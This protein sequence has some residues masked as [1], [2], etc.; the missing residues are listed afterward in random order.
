MEIKKLS[1]CTLDEILMAWNRGFEGY[2]VTIN[3][4][5]QLFLNRMVA[6]G[7]SFD[8]SIVAFVQGEP[9]G[10]VVNGIRTIKDKIVAWN[11]GT[12]V[13]PAYRGKGVSKKLMDET[14]VIYEEA[15]VDIAVLEAIKENE[16]A[17]QLYKRYGYD[18]TDE[19]VFLTGQWAFDASL[20]VSIYYEHLHPEQLA[21]LPFYEHY[22]PWQCQWQSVKQGE[23]YVFYNVEGEAIGYSLLKK[24]WNTEGK[25]DQ[26]VL[27]QLELIDQTQ[28]DYL[29]HMLTAIVESD[30]KIATVNFSKANPVTTFL[31]E[32]NFEISTEQAL[33]RKVM[34]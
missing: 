8:H 4:T 11:G 2:F 31:I 17:I 22:S 28:V 16:V 13:A 23:A 33:M 24:V 14:L 19:L 20:P 12:G 26:I 18:I 6:E 5:S 30:V 7:L 29:P 25:L 21:F 9:I 27:Y 32:H 3:M 15:K 34:K 10:I 1:Q